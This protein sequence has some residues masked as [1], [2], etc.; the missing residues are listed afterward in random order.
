MA[1]R[2]SETKGPTCFA[3]ET[4][5]QQVSF[6]MVLPKIKLFNERE[7]IYSEETP[8]FVTGHKSINHFFEEGNGQMSML[9]LETF[10]LCKCLPKNA[11]N[12]IVV[13]VGAYPGNHINFLTEMFPQVTFELYDPLMAEGGKTTLKVRPTEKVRIHPSSFNDR[14]AQKYVGKSVLYISDIRTAGYGKSTDIERNSEI[15][16]TDMW[17]QLRWSQIMKP[18][19]SLMRYRPKLL[20]ERPDARDNRPNVSKYLTNE[21]D[22]IEKRRLYYNYPTGYFLR[23]PMAK[24]NPQGMFL[25]TNKYDT[26]MKTYFHDD[27]L[28]LCR[29]HNEYVR[30]VMLYTNP[31]TGTFEGI[32][33]ENIVREYVARNNLTVKDNNYRRYVCGCDWD[34]RAMFYIM[35]LYIVYS[36]GETNPSKIKE[37]VIPRILDPFI[38]MEALST[39]TIIVNPEE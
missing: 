7:L 20:T 15:I 31:L 27:I 14:E 19:W 11:T 8:Q 34:H 6:E 23:I 29:Y 12:A 3:L 21:S 35:S 38:K 2:L 18:I 26:E 32:F 9:L 30:R 37:M 33:G 25:L 28:S 24:R 1:T 10:F 16:D 5:T 39:E 4:I 13:Y 36:T 17:D 22:P